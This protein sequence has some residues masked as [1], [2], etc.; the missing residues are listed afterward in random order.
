MNLLSSWPY[1]RQESI[2]IWSHWC[3]T[4]LL[5]W[6]CFLSPAAVMTFSILN[7]L[8]S[9][10]VLLS[11]QCI[12]NDFTIKALS[13]HA[14]K[15]F[16]VRTASDTKITYENGILIFSFTKTALSAMS[17]L[18]NVVTVHPLFCTFSPLH[19]MSQ[20]YFNLKFINERNT[21]QGKRTS[22]TS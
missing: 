16:L 21:F 12:A 3:L 18:I 17:S 19:F 20:I 4:L 11:T 9:W 8:P 22:C 10:F 7:L 5:S 2:A 6:F 1:F 14:G 15:K 13:R